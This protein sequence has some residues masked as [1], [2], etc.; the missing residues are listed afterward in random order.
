MQKVWFE[1]HPGLYS[2]EFEYFNFYGIYFND[3]LQAANFL[4]H[5]KYESDTQYEGWMERGI[6]C[7]K[8]VETGIVYLDDGVK[9]P[10][11]EFLKAYIK[12]IW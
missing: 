3:I 1:R 11:E 4:K 7:L 10:N 8:D 6:R 2:D 12:T 5:I 9:F